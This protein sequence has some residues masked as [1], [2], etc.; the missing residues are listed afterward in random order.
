MAL[1]GKPVVTSTTAPRA[2]LQ[3]RGVSPCQ[4]YDELEQRRAEGPVIAAPTIT[5]DGDADGVAPATGGSSYAKQFSGKRTPR[6]V[7]E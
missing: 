2:L 6:I 1:L 4:P 3:R 7:K 5:I